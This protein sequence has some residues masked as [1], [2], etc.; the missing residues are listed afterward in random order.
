[1]SEREY[2]SDEDNDDKWFEYNDEWFEKDY[3]SEENFKRN[4][5]GMTA[6]E[7]AD[8]RTYCALI[9]PRY[10]SGDILCYKADFYNY[11]EKLEN[12]DFEKIFVS[13]CDSIIDYNYYHNNLITFE[14]WVSICEKQN[15]NP[16]GIFLVRYSDRPTIAARWDKERIKC[17]FDLYNRHKHSEPQVQNKFKKDESVFRCKE[18]SQIEKE[19]EVY[20][21]N[22]TMNNVKR[23]KNIKI[24]TA[25]SK[26]QNINQTHKVSLIELRFMMYTYK[27]CHIGEGIHDLDYCVYDN[28]YTESKMQI[29]PYSFT[30][31]R[32]LLPFLNWL[33]FYVIDFDFIMIILQKYLGSEK[34]I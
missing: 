9:D 13:D 22:N 20:W 19:V 18:E 23:Y 34:I 10:Y 27:N 6:D 3:L 28:S 29:I 8:S 16:L 17:F 4:N 32:I 11:E 31:S 15:I 30:L 24:H 2:N 26:I 21:K 12:D 1:M 14:E 5:E 7:W 25:E 33:K